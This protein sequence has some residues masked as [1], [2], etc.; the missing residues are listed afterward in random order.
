MVT[1][2]LNERRFRAIDKHLR[3]HK[4]EQV[5]FLFLSGDVA[6]DGAIFEVADHYI[7]PQE[8]LIRESEFH[9]EVSEEAQARVIKMASDK[10][11]S[12]GEIHSHPQSLED[13]AFSP[14]DFEGFKEFV[15]HIWWRLKGKPYVALVFGRNSFDALAW[16]GDPEDPIGIESLEVGK[17]S[18]RSTGIS[19]RRLRE[20]KDRETA[21]YS[22][23]MMLFGEEGQA[24]IGKVRVVIVGLGGIGSH[25]AQQLAYL[26][27]R[28]Y[29]LIDEDTI[30]RSNLNRLIGA[31]ESELGKKKVEVITRR[32][33]AVQPEAEVRTIDKS[34]LS[35][36]AY[37]AFVE[38]GVVFGCVD[39]DGVRLV[40][41]ELCCTYRRPYLDIATDA[42]GGVSFGGRMIF[43]GLGKGC[44]M[45]RQELDQ[46]EMQAFF[47]T[48]EQRQERKR[49]YGVDRAALGASGPSVVSL[50]GLMASAAVIE[51]MTFVT[52]L[53]QPF[54]FLVY[55]GDLG[56]VTRPS[57]AP[58]PG[59]YYC[60]GL[61]SGRERLDPYRY[62]KS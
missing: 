53:R 4:T 54:P 62:L 21:R 31:T 13:A 41:L 42:P 19:A 28:H 51:F 59:C 36:E 8:D 27:V 20:T 18:L 56:V 61:W 47:E 40:L 6:S 29:V 26:G 17:Q 16:I 24:K 55:R 43:T 48:P 12:L 30:S 32:L 44:P 58:T 35:R 1:V 25:V 9:A 39:D 37:G 10:Q 14:S 38:A 34:L 50:N 7:V 11:L 49:I 45:C 23:Q 3:S 22:R 15:P 33:T 57:E 60:E 2:R 52:G 46:E 5:I